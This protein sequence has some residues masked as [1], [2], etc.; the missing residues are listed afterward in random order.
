M[1]DTISHYPDRQLARYRAVSIGLAVF[2]FCIGGAALLGWI[3]DNPYLKRIH[4]S[5]VTMKAN[6]AVCLMLVAVSVLL[7][8]DRSSSPIKRSIHLLFA[9]IVG[10]VGL[11]TLSE[12]IFG[13]NSGLD[14]LLFYESLAEAGQS[15]PGRMG[16]AASLN[17]SF[18][19]IALSFFDARGKRWFRVSNIAVLLVVTV[20][21]LVFLY[22]FYGIEQLEPLALYFT[23]A[24]HTVIAFL[25]LCAALLLARTERGFVAALLGNSPGAVVA[26]RM[27]PAFVV[28]ILLG[29]IRTMARNAGWFSPGFATAFFVLA[30]L[31]L[32]A[33]LIWLTALSLNRTDRER[34]V[35][36]LALRDSEARLAALL[37]QLPVG[38]GLTDREGRFLIRNS[39]LNNFVGERLSSLDPVF[40][41]R[42]RAWDE[43]GRLLDPSE[44]PSARAMRG[45]SVS[46]G[47]EMLY[48][49]ANGK[50]IWT[51]VLSVPFRNEADELSGVIV[52]VQDIDEQRRAENRLDVLVRVS[53]LIRTIHDPYELSYAVA[54]T[55][56]SHLQV[57]RCLFNETDVERDLEI[58][59][60]DYTDG[61]DSV[62]GE[63]RISE[64]S[65]ITTREM[66]LGNTVVNNDSKT[67]PRTAVDFDRIYEPNGERAYVAVP[68]MREGRWVASLWVSNDR[69]RQWTKEELS[70]LQTVAERTWTAIEKLRAETERERLL[71]SV[72]EAR[73]AAEKANQLKDEFLATLSHELRN[74]LNVILGYSELLLRMR[75]IEQSPR[76]VQMGEALRRNAQ[77]QSQLINDLLDLS[78]LQRGKISL[79]Q[80]T[81]SMPAIV[82]NAVETVR[83]D[84]AAKGIDIRVNVGDQLLLVEG[85]RLRLQQIAWNLL[86]NAVKFTPAGGSIEIALRNEN[87]SAVFVV[88][89]TGQGIDASFLPHVFEMFRQADGSN[90]RRH[91]GMGIGLA[92]VHQLVQLHGGEISAASA[93]P[94]KGACFTVRLPLLPETARLGSP[95]A[96]GAVELNVF[97][98]TNFLI[99]D[100]SEDTIAMLQDLLRVAGANVM[101]A[102]NGADA[103]RLAAEN[104]FDVILSDISMPEMDGYE[105]LQRLRK[106]EGRQNVPVVAITGFGRRDD[107]ARARAAGFYSHL[108]KPLNLQVL[109]E[110]L[111]Q[112]GN[113]REGL[114][115]S[116]D[117]DYDISAGPVF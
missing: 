8:N 81:V 43:E 103:L 11:I 29:W 16:V 62:A 44:W 4:P 69:P 66:Q 60:R 37:E 38:I 72:Q 2:A 57:R 116:T 41:A 114:S 78:R 100:D 108:T 56:G 36:E 82:D 15:F 31:L 77:S 117:V 84:A 113:E 115:A 39:L 55:L 111:Q 49:A 6:T 65:S 7:Y 89:D 110:V 10:L 18:L 54:E 32:L 74:P 51:R 48:T 14:Q 52:V 105:F 85:D 3:L 23:I 92:L 102:T 22:Y 12:H 21:L 80:E 46:P 101:T 109:T 42:W 63:H 45:E 53:E 96:T 50:Q 58:V 87:E 67:D 83:A 13:W 94:N 112:L 106:I 64:Y 9:A 40:A 68:L 97:V 99:V 25:C 26:R 59:H 88:T 61:A 90:R 19:G 79:N 20:T 75:E 104:E 73:D 93:G 28:V 107:I 70:L 76:L 5:L 98:Q 86:N 35:A 1:P 34:R 91:G 95:A 33:V 71:T 27:L 17:F 30:V 24:L 47:C